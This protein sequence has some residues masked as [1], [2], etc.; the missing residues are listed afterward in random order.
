[1]K[2]ENYD[3]WDQLFMNIA[4]SAAKRSKDPRT[5]HGACIITASNTVVS[6]GYNGLSRLLNDDGNYKGTSYWDRELKQLVCIHAEQNAILNSTCNL[7]GTTIYLSSERGY[8]P[9]PVCASMISQVGI[10][11]VVMKWATKEKSDKYDWELS[12]HIL[13]KSG[14][15]IK[16]LN[17]EKGQ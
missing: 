17:E 13:L 16:I 6:V 4:D 14:I 8:Y 3:S 7:K 12:K 11:R 1:M 15:D 2:R 9:C 5:Q 10:R